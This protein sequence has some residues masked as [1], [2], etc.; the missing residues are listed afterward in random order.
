[1]TTLYATFDGQVL[2]PEEPIPLPP[3]TRV[4]LHL[5]PAEIEPACG[6]GSSSFLSVAQS[7]NLEGPPDWSK[8]IGRPPSTGLFVST[9][10][11]LGEESE[12]F[13]DLND[14]E[15]R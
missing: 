4:R 3:N 13:K 7:L 5:E 8:R 11:K 1:M 15:A 10:P 12:L 2:V 9:D 6:E 14:D